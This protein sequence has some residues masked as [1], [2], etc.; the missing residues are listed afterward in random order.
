MKLWICTSARPLKPTLIFIRVHQCVASATLF[1]WGIA[2]ADVSR[3]FLHGP[4]GRAC[5]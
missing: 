4:R 1:N 3:G 5:A 2:G